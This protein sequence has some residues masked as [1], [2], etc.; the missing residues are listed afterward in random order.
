MIRKTAYGRTQL[1]LPSATDTLREIR[2]KSA[3]R[4]VGTA[5]VFHVLERPSTPVCCWHCCEVIGTD[6]PVPIPRCYDSTDGVFHVFGATCSPA[7]AKAYVIE[8][9][10]FDRGKHLATLSMM[11]RDA[12]G[13]HAPVV[14]TPPRASL[15]KFG[16]PFY[17]VHTRP[18]ECRQIEPPF[19]SYTMIV[20]ERDMQH[21]EEFERATVSE[22]ITTEPPPESMF[23][24]FVEQ[25]ASFEPPTPAAREPRRAK[26]ARAVAVGALDRFIEDP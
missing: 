24:A 7:C 25:R 2:S 23:D 16:G 1:F 9:S 3:V 11:F 18:T 5:S 22:E 20:E 10:S 4:R 19:V 14:E 6:D 8:H 15:R 12:Y 13:I 21:A 26:R 17:P